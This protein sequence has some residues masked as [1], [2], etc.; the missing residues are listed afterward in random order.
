MHRG[1]LVRE[2]L[3][4]L[5]AFVLAVIVER[6]SE[7]VLHPMVVGPVA[8]D[9]TGSPVRGLDAPTGEDACDLD[10]IL[11]GVPAV[12]TKGVELEE[13][14]RIVFV[15]AGGPTLQTLPALFGHLV[16]AKPS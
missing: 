16:H 7:D 3:Q 11:L 14:A 6:E 5:D 8:K 1:V 10:D 12:N 9:E 4:Q 2:E 13:L 15:D